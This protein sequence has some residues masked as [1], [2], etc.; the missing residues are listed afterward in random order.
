MARIDADRLS[1]LD[2]YEISVQN[3][4]LAAALLRA[5]HGGPARVLQEDFSGSAAVSRAWIRNAPVARAVAVDLD[6]RALAR[7]RR[8]AGRTARLRTVR[9]DALRCPLAGTPRPDVVFVGNFSIGEIHE[10]AALVRYLERCRDRLAPGGVFVCDTYGGATAFVRGSSQ[11]TI[12]HPRDASLRI[13]YTW[14]QRAADPMTARVENAIHFRLIRGRDVLRDI[15]DAFVYRWR[16]WSLPELRDAAAEAG[17]GDTAVYA[18]IPDAADSA[19]NAYALPV[20]SPDEL[21]DS[22]IVCV[23]MRVPGKQRRRTKTAAGPRFPR[24]PRQVGR[25]M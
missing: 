12:P 8:L 24:G 16:L 15:T 13:L 17:L 2:L 18:Q 10:R 14:E 22:F 4:P 5:I 23:A 1:I 19:G 11:R 20:Q 6:A 7:A 25:G 9:G 3:P 21:G